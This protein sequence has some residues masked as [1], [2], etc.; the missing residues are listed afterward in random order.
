ML[1]DFLGGGSGPSLSALGSPSHHP[2][3]SPGPRPGP[4]GPS[5][6]SSSALAGRGRGR[7]CGR[8]GVCWPPLPRVPA[9]RHAAL[10]LARTR[11]PGE[12]SQ[13]ACQRVRT[14]EQGGPGAHARR[15][16]WRR[17]QVLTVRGLPG[18]RG[19][20]A[21]AGVPA[22]PVPGGRTGPCAQEAESWAQS[23]QADGTYWTDRPGREM[24]GAAGNPRSGARPAR[25]RGRRLPGSRFLP[26][27]PVCGAPAADRRVLGLILVKDMPTR[28]AASVTPSHDLPLLSTQEARPTGGFLVLSHLCVPGETL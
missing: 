23:I 19:T 16:S 20:Q 26:P 9:G 17:R 14:K 22:D 5:R 21:G 12:A 18:H 27:Q 15:A 8:G 7:L 11:R 2:L 1:C 4:R 24:K 10:R 28:H 25:H 13:T 6:G 3:P